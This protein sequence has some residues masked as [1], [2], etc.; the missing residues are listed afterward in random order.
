MI[1]GVNDMFWWLLLLLIFLLFFVLLGVAGLV[2]AVVFGL[3]D[4]LAGF[5]YDPAKP[6]SLLQQDLARLRVWWRIRSSQT[7]TSRNRG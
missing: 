7:L 1:S 5:R 6:P 2:F 4:I 3:Y